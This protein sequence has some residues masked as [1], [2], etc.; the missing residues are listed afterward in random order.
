MANTDSRETERPTL[1]ELLKVKQHERPSDDYWERFERELHAKPWQG[2]VR[3][4]ALTRVW[5][6]FR[7]FALPAIPVGTTAAFAL[8]IYYGGIAVNPVVEVQPSIESAPVVVA[9]APSEIA[10]VVAEEVSEVG[11]SQA[12]DPHFVV[13]SFST[14]ESSDSGFTTVPTTHYMPASQRDGVHFAYNTIGRSANRSI[15]MSNGPVRSFY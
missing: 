6:G 1:E 13:G 12:A 2:M 14:E 15:A 11:V 7:S 9:E 4:S 5:E 10:S 8:A 3:A